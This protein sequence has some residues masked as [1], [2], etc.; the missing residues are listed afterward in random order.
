MIW[1]DDE[2][3]YR[4]ISNKETVKYH[5]IK[6]APVI[7]GRSVFW[8]YRPGVDTGPGLRD[9]GDPVIMPNPV[10][11]HRRIIRILW[12]TALLYPKVQQE[13]LIYNILYI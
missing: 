13:S 11:D 9:P 2:K 8:H 5:R 3:Q 12:Q 10:I 6:S 4:K 7:D 1:D